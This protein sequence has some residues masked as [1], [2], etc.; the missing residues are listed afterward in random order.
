MAFPI[1]PNRPRPHPL[2]ATVKVQ[3]ANTLATVMSMAMRNG[4]VT[5]YGSCLPDIM[6]LP[7][8]PQ[9]RVKC[10]D[11]SVKTR[12]ERLDSV[13]PLPTDER[14]AEVGSALTVVAIAGGCELTD[15]ISGLQDVAP[16]AHVILT[17]MITIGVLDNFYDVIK[18]TSSFAMQQV[19]KPSSSDNSNKKTNNINLP[20]L[21]S[22][23]S[24]PLGLG[25][26]EAT[27]QIVRGL[28]R[29]LTIDP[30]RDALAEAA[31]LF[32]AYSL[33]L[34]VFCFRPNAL[35]ASVLA[36]ENNK[37]GDGELLSDTGLLRL[38]VWLLAP[39]AAE[40]AQY[41]VLISSDPREAGS[42]LDRLQQVAATNGPVANA[43]WWLEDNMEMDEEERND[44]LQWAYTE[45]DVLLRD[46]QRVVRE[47]AERLEGGAATIGDCIALLEQW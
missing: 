8:T 15:F 32:A 31:G 22:K 23:E 38:L 11:G 33:G 17:A 7:S 6:A 5:S 3:E 4:G 47:L 34:P 18:T 19:N 43:L 37:E 13:P 1:V 29:L 36:V 25:S 20:E 41:P 2:Q 16:A 46:N 10:P 44:L 39:V 45:A 30:A 28:T 26:G 14:V 12:Q 40:S 27:G 24:L 21:P 35:E 9:T 42:F